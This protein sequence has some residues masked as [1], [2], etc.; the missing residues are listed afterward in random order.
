MILTNNLGIKNRAKI[1]QNK[2][3]TLLVNIYQ[4]SNQLKQPEQIRSEYI[5][6]FHKRFTEEI[7]HQKNI[8]NLYEKIERMQYD[9]Y[10]KMGTINSKIYA[11]SFF[12]S[13]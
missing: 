1:I 9:H 13:Q 5:Q 6:Y 4:K 12:C 8:E 11:M 3:E 2:C 10:Q 7:E